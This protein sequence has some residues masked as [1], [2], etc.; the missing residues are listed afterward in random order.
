RQLVV[1][2]DGRVLF[3][4]AIFRAELNRFNGPVID[5]AIIGRVLADG[6]WDSSF[7]M[8]TCGLPLVQESGPFWFDFPNTRLF[9]RGEIPMPTAFVAR[10]VDG[11]VVLAGAF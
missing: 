8:I 7:T 2:P 9:D 11:V 5:R 1:Q 3:I 10:Q 4:A 6:S